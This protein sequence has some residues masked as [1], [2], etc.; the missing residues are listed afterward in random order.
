MPTTNLT[1]Q[2][3]ADA[4]VARLTAT[5][6]N[7][8]SF[9]ASG[10]VM[11]SSNVGPWLKDGT[12][13]WVWDTGLATYVVQPTAA[14][15]LGYVAQQAPGP[16]HTVY[17]FWI[18]LDGA[19]AA[20]SIQYYSSGAWHDIYAA[21]FAAVYAAIAAITSPTTGALLTY[22]VACTDGGTHQTI[23]VN[24]AYQ[25]MNLVKY[26]DP[27]G[28]FDNA[29]SRYNVPK[30]GIYQVS[31]IHQF[32]NSTAT[33]S[34]MQIGVSFYINGAGSGAGT[35]VAIASP[36]G[37]R[38]F[39]TF[40]AFMSLNAGDYVELFCYAT[41][42]VNTGNIISNNVNCSIHQIQ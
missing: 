7:T 27:N 40:T 15:S 19:G 6:T 39:P 31:S 32:D 36:P 37:S 24:G 34:G 5:S 1:P 25:K 8:I 16:D 33:A 9:F 11:P 12:S 17:T 3:F 23:A 22:P 13:W 41:D 26:I 2:Q 29:T 38:W 18:Q 28:V 4:I 14:V 30:T 35:T 21:Q 10:S 42:G 20:Q